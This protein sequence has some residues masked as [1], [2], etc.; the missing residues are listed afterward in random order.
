MSR[1][2]TITF[3][4]VDEES[5]AQGDFAETGWID[6][7]GVEITPDEYDLD[8]AD[9][10]EIAAVVELAKKTI[11]QNGCVEPSSSQFHTG[12]WYTQ[13]DC[14]MGEERYSFHLNDFLPEEE[15]AVYNAITAN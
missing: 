5:A 12:V 4:V 13:V 10:D 6:E 9:G 1:R 11:L 7:E 2:I 8:D 3:D 15:E 14:P